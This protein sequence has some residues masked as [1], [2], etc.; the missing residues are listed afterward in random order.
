MDKRFTIVLIVIFLILGGLFFYTHQKAKAPGAQT[1]ITTSNH[2]RGGNAKNVELVVYGDFECSVCEPFYYIEKQAL[3]KYIGDIKITFRHFPLDGI[4][5]N[6]RAASRAAEAAGLQGKFFEMHDMLYENQDSWIELNS[7]LKTFETYAT[8][9][10]LDIEKFQTDYAS[11]V[12]ND[13]INADYQEGVS[14]GVEGTPTYFLNGKKLN[15][16]DIDNAEKFA[17]KIEA[18]IKT[19]PN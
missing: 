7:P 2:S 16:A 9:L 19:T 17:S 12:V 11:A 6:A 18:A 15:N 14:K 4:H 10:K 13:T 5:P 8:T 3:E 1:T